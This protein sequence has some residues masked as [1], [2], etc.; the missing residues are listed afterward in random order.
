MTTATRQQRRSNGSVLI[1]VVNEI[2][3]SGA[4]LFSAI[5]FVGLDADGRPLSYGDAGKALRYLDLVCHAVRKVDR[6]RWR[7]LDLGRVYIDERDY[8]N[9]VQG[10]DED[11]PAVPT[12]RCTRCNL[13]LTASESLCPICD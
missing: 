10:D 3:A 5:D 6:N 13:T 1:A 12:H 2:E 9:W 4:K 8:D 7:V 11:R